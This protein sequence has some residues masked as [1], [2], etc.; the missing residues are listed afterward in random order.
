MLN[1]DTNYVQS[2]IIKFSFDGAQRRK[3]LVKNIKLPNEQVHSPIYILLHL[4]IYIPL[5][6]RERHLFNICTHAVY[7][8]NYDRYMHMS[9]REPGRNRKNNKKI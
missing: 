4:Y 6:I 5:Y 8:K 1:Y 3:P 2:L 7:R 9:A